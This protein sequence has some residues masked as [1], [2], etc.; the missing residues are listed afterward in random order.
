MNKRV[1]STLRP[2][3]GR[4]SELPCEVFRINN[5][6]GVVLRDHATQTAKGK[7]SYDLHLGKDGLVHPKTG[8]MFE[9]PNGC[10]LRSDGP[11][12]Q[13]LVRGAKGRNVII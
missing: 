2:L 5:G 3:L 7:T 1:K 12:L 10:S 6:A 8:D 13:E 11:F 4:Y 9:G